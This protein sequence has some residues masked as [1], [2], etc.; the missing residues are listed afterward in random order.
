MLTIGDRFP[1]YT[2]TAVVSNDINNAFKEVTDQ[3]AKGKW[4][5]YFFYPKDFTFICPTEIAQF[6]NLNSEFA[7]NNA[8]V[9]GVSTDSDFVHLAW[10]RSHPDLMNLHFPLISDIRRDLSI[11]LGVL[12]RKEG[13]CTRATFIVDPEGTIRYAAANDLDV[14]RNVDDILRILIALQTGELCA[15]NWN[16]GDKFLKKA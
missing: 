16:P 7:K 6:N 5:V 1:N 11:S 3:S 8:Q 14:G 2:A 4:Q 15:C 12:D 10:R 9:Y 13:V